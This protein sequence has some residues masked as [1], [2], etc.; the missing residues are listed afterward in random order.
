MTILLHAEATPDPLTLR[1]ITASGGIPPEAI[2]RLIAEGTLDRVEVVGTEILT[3]LAPGHSWPIDGP[4]VRSALFQAFS[5]AEPKD[6]LDRITG[7]LAREV[8][9]FM[10]SHGGAIR[11]LSVRDDVVEV[12]LDGTCGNCSFRNQTLGNIITG[13]VRAAFPHI[14]EVRAVRS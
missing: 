10:T 13:A 3:R 7:L 2:D 5:D 14:R 11:V 4:R 12:A 9:P 1:W 6:L 8:G